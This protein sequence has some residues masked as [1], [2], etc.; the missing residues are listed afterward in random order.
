MKTKS[1]KKQIWILTAVF[2]LV[3]FA[4]I[5]SEL[6]LMQPKPA[7]MVEFNALDETQGADVLMKSL[8]PEPSQETLLTAVGSD[9][10]VQFIGTGLA[11]SLALGF[12]L[13]L[14]LKRFTKPI[15]K[16]AQA[17]KL[18]QRE[19]IEVANDYEELKSIT[20]SF[21]AVIA[22]LNT[23]LSAQKR[24]NASVAHELKTPLSIIK[25][26]ID[27]LNSLPDKTVKD[28]Q[29][30]LDIIHQSV[31][32]MNA[33][34][35]TLLDTAQEGSESLNDEMAIDEILTDVVE[36][37]KPYAKEKQV[38]LSIQVE[39]GPTTTGNQVLLY[40]SF[41]NLIENAIKYNRPNGR[42]HVSSQSTREGFEIKVA[43]TGIGIAEKDIREIFEP[44]YR[45][46]GTE[47]KEGLGLGLSL[48]KSVI[49]MHSGSITVASR[50]GEG[51]VFEVHLPLLKKEEN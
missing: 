31:R 21:N 6:F 47:S 45:V 35:D 43:D 17:M 29:E 11:L 50:P 49:Q 10:T 39:A 4:V 27:V 3:A 46:S 38:S 28:Y 30:T 37:L 18:D 36:D 14:G 19:P 2:S 32:K 13:N 8:A 33:L 9:P 23:S 51:S 7:E 22:K 41:Y 26:H 1:L 40:R 44:F 12:L 20:A 24:F 5:V 15:D 25:T 34:V 16:L 42:V 48:V